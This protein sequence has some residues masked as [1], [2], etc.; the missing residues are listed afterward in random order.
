MNH[1]NLSIDG[2]QCVIVIVLM[3]IDKTYIKFALPLVHAY[4]FA[5]HATPLSSLT[6]LRFEDTNL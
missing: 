1:Y 6:F 3:L 5:V 4:I 2:L